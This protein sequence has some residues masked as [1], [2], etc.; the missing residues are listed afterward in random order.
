MTEEIQKL[1][2]KVKDLQASI[3]RQMSDLHLL[4][5]QRDS[6]LNEWRAQLVKVSSLCSADN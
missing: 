4:M 2:Y 1:E 6:Q 3:H 5:V